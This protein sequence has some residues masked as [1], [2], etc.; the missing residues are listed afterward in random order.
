VL[1]RIFGPNRN[2]TI[3]FGGDLARMG[4]KRNTYSVLMEQPGGKRPLGRPRRRWVDNTEM[5]LRD[6]G[7][8]CMDWVDLVQDRDQ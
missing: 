2:E 3:E 4:S 6:V 1:R 8:G 7:W 5:D